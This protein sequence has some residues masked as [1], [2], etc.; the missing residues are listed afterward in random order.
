M[1]FGCAG[2]AGLRARRY[3]AAYTA[4]KSALLVLVRSWAREEASHGLHVNMVSPG[5]VP[6][7]DAH[8]E[9]L[10]SAPRV[11]GVVERVR[12]RERRRV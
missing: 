2:L 6:H 8:P 1:F 7:D 3:A 10:Q 4:A 5:I 12:D 11:E 9:T